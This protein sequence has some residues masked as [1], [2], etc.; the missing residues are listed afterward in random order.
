MGCLW[1]ENIVH[2]YHNEAGLAILTQTLS[3]VHRETHGT[4]SK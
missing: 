4:L 2:G 3:F 1:E